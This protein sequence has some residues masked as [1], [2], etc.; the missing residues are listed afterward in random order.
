[1]YCRRARWAVR[2]KPPR[3]LLYVWSSLGM[4]EIYDMTVLHEDYK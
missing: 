3:K 1:M 2:V 4:T